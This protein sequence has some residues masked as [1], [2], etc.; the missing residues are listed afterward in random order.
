LGKLI[1]E[2]PEGGSASL[3]ASLSLIA[4]RCSTGT[5]AGIDRRY[6]HHAN[7]SRPRARGR[8]EHT[9]KEAQG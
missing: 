3:P 9:P 1:D 8:H 4:F 6:A 2:G 5:K 7:G